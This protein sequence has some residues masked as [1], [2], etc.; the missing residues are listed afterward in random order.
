M[1]GACAPALA[2]GLSIA[3]GAGAATGSTPLASAREYVM[4]TVV[5]LRIHAA[6]S[7]AAAA[8]ALEAA[9]DEIRTVD[10]LMAV[11]RADSQVS[12]LNREAAR[13]PVSVDRRVVEVLRASLGASRLTGGAFDVT[14]LP[15]ARAFG[16]TDGRP[17][18]V[19]GPV[20]RIAGWRHV[21][22]D[23]TA[24]TVHFTDPGVEIDLG[25]IAKGYALDRARGIL[26]AEGVG[27]AYLD[28]GG[29]IA[30]IGQPP[31]GDHWRIG[32]RHPRRPESL[33][34]VLEVGET[35]VSTS[36]DGE[37]YL[38][39]GGR[40]LGHVID[41]RAGRPADALMSA[42]VVASS[43]TMADAL[44]TA[45]VVLGAGPMERLLTETDGEG[46]FAA[47]DGRG[48]L[49]LTVT[50]GAPFRRR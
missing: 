45:A 10:R 32:I 27:S 41:P 26:R 47:P 14:V 6:A 16:F 24:G 40:R 21:A 39:A 42:T 20:P 29:E 15:V 13:R 35:A 28:L 33:L 50:R 31:D 2:A 23:A 3:T 36:G 5:E 9:L 1:R 17:H 7:P 22:V 4:G 30:T 49:T 44:S 46:V 43:A 48:G 25:G 37:Q 18:P 8:R 12:R 34:G 11:Q 19:S 38:R